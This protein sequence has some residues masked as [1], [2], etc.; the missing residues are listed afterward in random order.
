M[1]QNRASALFITISYSIV[2]LLST[3]NVSDLKDSEE[4]RGRERKVKNLFFWLD[5]FWKI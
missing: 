3:L 4:T 5:D 1:G 2:T